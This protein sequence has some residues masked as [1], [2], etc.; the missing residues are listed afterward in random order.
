MRSNGNGAATAASHKKHRLS[1]E[2]GF[3]R[4][5]PFAAPT[6]SIQ[7]RREKQAAKVGAVVARIAGAPE[8]RPRRLRFLVRFSRRLVRS[9]VFFLG[10]AVFAASGMPAAPLQQRFRTWRDFSPS[11]SRSY[12][13]ARLNRRSVFFE[14][15]DRIVA[16]QISLCRREE[17]QDI[18][19]AE[20]MPILVF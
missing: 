17:N 7:N 14:K 19:D 13:R 9:K 1:S 20:E 18:L 5:P 2:N 15:R 12:R 10:R 4:R 11:I 6:G 3:Q 8:K 16:R